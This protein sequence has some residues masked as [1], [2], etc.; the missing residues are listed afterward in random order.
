MIENFQAFHSTLHEFRTGKQ[1]LALIQ[2][3]N[4]VGLKSAL[5]DFHA[6][7]SRRP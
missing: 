5:P 7:P 2:A 4:F 1:V 3:Y 6:Y